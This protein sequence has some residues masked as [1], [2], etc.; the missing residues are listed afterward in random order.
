M[1]IDVL[2]GE[3]V[4]AVDDNARNIDSSS[5]LDGEYVDR[6]GVLAPEAGFA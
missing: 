1:R 3:G 2:L 4:S 6:H 5:A